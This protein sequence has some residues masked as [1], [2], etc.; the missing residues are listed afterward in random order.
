MNID[1]LTYGELKQIAAMF[2]SKSEAEPTFTP[3][4]GKEC[5]VRTYASGV[6]F[7]TVVAQSGRQVE[8]KDAR[9]LWKWH[10]KIGISL[11][12]LAIDGIDASKSRICAAVPSI[13]ITDAL[14][15]IPASPAAAS[16]IREAPVASK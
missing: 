13:T 16:T 11:S 5:I 15:L 2:G 4:I 12:E 8:I 3:H 7:G 6:H 9:R 10:A 1:N 14:E